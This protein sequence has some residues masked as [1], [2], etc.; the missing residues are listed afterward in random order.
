M[1]TDEL[2]ETVK[3]SIKNQRWKS[4]AKSLHT[5]LKLEPE[6]SVA[7]SAVGYV[8]L[9]QER[10]G[11]SLA[12][13]R[14]ALAIDPQD[15][16]AL[17]F[18]PRVL[19]DQGELAAAF[20]E[21]ITHQEK[22]ASSP[23]SAKL[24]HEIRNT[25]GKIVALGLDFRTPRQELAVQLYNL[26]CGLLNQERV[27][28]AVSAFELCARFR[29][30]YTEPS[31]SIGSTLEAYRR[32][33]PKGSYRACHWL[34]SG[35]HF[36]ENCLRFCCTSHSGDKGWTKI[37][38]YNGGS[39]P[40]DAILAVRLK[41]ILD[42]N[43]GIENE[44]TGCHSLTDKEWQQGDAVFDALIIN[45]Y[46][47]CNFRCSY[48]TLTQKNFEMPAYY[49][50]TEKAFAEMVDN[51]WLSNSANITWGGGDPCVSKEFQA[52]T[53]RFTEHGCRTRANTNAS[54]PVPE[55]KDALAK[56]QCTLTISVDAG[57]K[58][59]FYR[60]KMNRKTESNVPI[61]VKSKE[62]Y[63]AVWETVAE[64]AAIDADNVRLKYIFIEDNSDPSELKMFLDMCKKS[65]VKHAVFTPEAEFMRKV[66]LEADALPPKIFEAMKYAAAYATASGFVVQYYEYFPAELFRP[67]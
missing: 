12:L 15:D 54:V 41:T 9:E 66:P 5:V 29:P 43:G 39:L 4:A 21:L 51:E 60:V 2:F 6:N 50:A 10:L 48:C 18:L 22:H 13:F 62:V 61:T 3:E 55:I 35:L 53:Q 24:F 57:S 25:F 44:C 38:D 23:E 63:S 1:G 17:Q 58:A 47:V 45:S 30:D 64:Y 19:C 67:T 59:A 46:S 40:L 56:G 34:V 32:L 26:A 8:R 20:Q 31:F 65:G 27:D 49:Y 7:L 28:D 11:E 36:H 37:L 14:R 16:M 33:M 52:A 42:L